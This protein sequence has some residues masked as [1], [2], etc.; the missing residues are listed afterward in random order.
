[1][2]VVRLG[3]F[4]GNTERDQTIGTA[5][6]GPSNQLEAL[7]RALGSAQEELKRSPAER[8]QQTSDSI[9]RIR[10]V[11]DYLRASDERIGDLQ[12]GLEAIRER[13]RREIR[14]AQERS[15][16]AEARVSAEAARA[17]AAEAR[18]REAEE[19]LGEIMVVIEQELRAGRAA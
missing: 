19:R 9:D 8:Q 15:E 4:T 10:E 2:G 18:A 13:A 5:D 1:M 6:A 17:D 12:A 7:R 11:A 14:A 3:D 16:Q